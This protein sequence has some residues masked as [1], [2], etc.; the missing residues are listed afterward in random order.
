MELNLLHSYARYF[1]PP[2][3]EIGCGNG[4]FSSLLLDEMDVGVDL[5]FHALLRA[6]AKGVHHHLVQADASAHLPLPD[7]FVRTVI[8]NSVLE[9]FPDVLAVV[10][11]TAR[12]LM[13]GGVF[14]FTTYTNHLTHYLAKWF[15][16]E[17]AKTLN[18]HWQHVSLL[19]ERDWLALLEADSLTVMELER[20]LPEM[21]VVVL[22]LMTSSIVRGVEWAS[23]RFIWMLARRPMQCLVQRSLRVRRGAGILIIAAEPL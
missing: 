4:L 7:A 18:R 1:K 21:T 9:H 2:I 6:K 10:A 16:W 22:R 3:V 19:S 14:V 23:R 11:E 5:D 13:P 15:G 17:D 20:Y 8:S 12:V